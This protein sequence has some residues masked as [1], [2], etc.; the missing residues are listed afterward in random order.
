MRSALIGVFFV[1]NAER[2]RQYVRASARITH[3]DPRAEAAAQAV[4][5]AAAYAASGRDLAELVPALAS[6]CDDEAWLRATKAIPEHLVAGSTPRAYAAALSFEKGVSGYALQSVP[7]AL[8]AALRYP[9]DV[10]T[11][12]EETIACGGDTDTTAAMVGGIL[13]ARCGP[14]GMPQS[15]LEHFWD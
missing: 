15:W 12:L 14:Q 9:Y 11:A 4:A 6:Y 5:D 3:T 10:R 8:Y 7:V 2:C 13:G 1:Q